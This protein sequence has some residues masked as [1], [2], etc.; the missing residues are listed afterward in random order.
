MG[1]RVR[2]LGE[3]DWKT[4]REVRL[5]ALLESP[6]SFYS[7]YEEAHRL[8][9]DGWR[10]RL[11]S[12][13]RVTL[14]AELDGRGVGMIVGA[15]AGEDEQMDDA[16]LMLAMWVEPESRGQGVADALTT[17]LL[18]WSRAQGYGTLLLWVYGAAPRAAAFY[19][20][21]GF[22]PTG[23]VETFGDDSRPLTLMAQ[24]L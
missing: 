19:R 15:P 2:V 7:T 12:A 22:V 20:R 24:A 1:L 16:A 8:D 23:R 9:E 11:R 13:E 5:R 21:A 6:G 17:A 3:D 4:L 14:L 10:E 18:D